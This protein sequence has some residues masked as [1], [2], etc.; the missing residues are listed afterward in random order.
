MADDECVGA[1]LAFSV[2]HVVIRSVNAITESEDDLG[3]SH[4][5][6]DNLLTDLQSGAAADPHY[7]DLIAAV[8]SGF[9]TDHA[10]IPTHVRQFWSIRDQL[11]TDGGLVLYGSR[12]VIPLALRRNVLTK[13]HAAHQGIVRTKRRAQQTVYCPG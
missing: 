2:R 13:L 6:S 3:S 5:L 7:L 4:H 8:E 11:S 9:S 1:E 12:I 10:L